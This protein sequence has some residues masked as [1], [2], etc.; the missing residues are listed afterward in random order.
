MV[1]YRAKPVPSPSLL[2]H[3][4]KM[5]AVVGVMS[6]FRKMGLTKG[7]QILRAP[8]CL[9]SNRNHISRIRRHFLSSNVTEA[10]PA[11]E[12]NWVKPAGR[13][14]GGGGFSSEGR[15]TPGDSSEIPDPG[16]SSLLEY[17]KRLEERL[18]CK[19]ATVYRGWTRLTARGGISAAFKPDAFPPQML[20][21]TPRLLKERLEF[22]AGIGITG[23]DALIIAADLPSVLSWNCPTFRDMLQLVVSD[24]GCNI[25][26][27]MSRTPYVFA[28]N[29]KQ[30]K[31]NVNKLASV[32]LSNEIIGHLVDQNPLI[33]AFSFQN[34]SLETI[35]FMISHHEEPED[36]KIGRSHM[37]MRE[38]LPRL[39]TQPFERP[40]EQMELDENFKKVTLFLKDLQIPPWVIA[41][42]NPKFFN[43]DVE[44]LHSALEFLMGRPLFFETELL[45]KLLIQRS[46][47]FM[48]FDVLVLK[49]RIQ[50]AYDILQSPTKLYKLLQTCF[51]F[52]GGDTKLE[53]N[54]KMFREYG[55]EDRHIAKLMT[56]KDFFSPE[57]S[58]L[59]D[60]MKFLLSVQSVTVKRISEYPLC[61]LKPLPL[62]QKRV[63]FLKE[64]NPEALKKVEL[65]K[66]FTTEH[67]EFVSQICGSTMDKYNKVMET[68]IK[69]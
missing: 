59:K 1:Q 12:S 15:E 54:I 6:R 60:K 25:V 13:E 62:L 22:L 33:L 58:D 8:G 19:H 31:D 50:L 26:K 34:E 55:L 28:L 49:Q 5:A 17:I 56:F 69:K 24:L 30:A 39:L 44:K 23:K 35:G 66:I 52:E 68:F 38:L 65:K 61:L 57:G 51:F 32:G 7:L 63:E 43:T 16:D 45:Q 53:E 18:A 36:V 46:E 2:A 27:L 64:V 11:D 14:R 10:R 48:D 67:K 41:V 37:G 3:V 42:S 4:S 29:Y 20:G 21:L 47:I 9:C 40:G